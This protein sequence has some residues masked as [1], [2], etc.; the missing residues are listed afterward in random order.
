LGSGSF[1]AAA[2]QPQ[3]GEIHCRSCF[4]VSK[5]SLHFFIVSFPASKGTGT[6][7]SNVL[8][9]L[10]PV[11]EI[12]IRLRILLFSLRCVERTEIMPAKKNS[13]K[14]FSK[15]S[16]FRLKMM[17]LLA[18]YEKKNEKKYFFASLKSMKEVGS[19]VGS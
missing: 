6:L 5:C 18:S 4:Q 14:N 17:C 13:T 2:D 16:F 19:G 7:N 3:S 9:L 1:A 10:K 15:N 8:I 11:L 12:R